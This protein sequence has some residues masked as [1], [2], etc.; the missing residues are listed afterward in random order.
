[1]ENGKLVESRKKR[2]TD[3][4]RPPWE[5]GE[6]RGWQTPPRPPWEGGFLVES[7]KSKVKSKMRDGKECNEPQKLNKKLL[8]FLL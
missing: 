7:Q 1:M 3:T 6:K 4:P 2:P 5:G 8:G